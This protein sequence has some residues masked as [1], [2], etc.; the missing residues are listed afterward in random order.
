MRVA[1]T[2]GELTGGHQPTPRHA[3]GSHGGTTKVGGEIDAE[4]IYIPVRARHD[5]C[6]DIIAFRSFPSHFTMRITKCA[7]LCAALA[8]AGAGA[9]A[10]AQADEVDILVVGGGA[11]GSYA[12]VRLREDFNKTIMVVEKANRLVSHLPS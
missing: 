9:G 1:A 11:S 6:F 10:N 8:G 7:F 3:R 5:D 4:C 12:A 2:A